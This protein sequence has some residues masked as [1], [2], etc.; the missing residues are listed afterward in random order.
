MVGEHS[1]GEVVANS[2]RIA[3]AVVEEVAGIRRIVVAAEGR[4]SFHTEAGEVHSSSRRILAE[5]GWFAS[6]TVGG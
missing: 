3:I 4:H 2:R 6:V 5:M 1:A